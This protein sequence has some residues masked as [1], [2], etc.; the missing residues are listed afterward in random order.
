MKN[1]LAYV[2]ILEEAGVPRVQAEA[3]ANA[4]GE[5]MDVIATI[6]SDIKDIKHQLNLI[7]Q[8]FIQIEQRLT[9][10]LGTIVS[11]AIGIA[12]TLAKLIT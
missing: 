2:K 4:M 11:I 8:R 6:Q 3:H 7:D 1:P 12:V 5:T 10:K 9:I